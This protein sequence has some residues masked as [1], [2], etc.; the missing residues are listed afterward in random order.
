MRVYPLAAAAAAA[1][2]GVAGCSGGD[3]P[4]PASDTDPAAMLET[5][6]GLL[7]Q[8]SGLRFTME[9]ENLP[10]AGMVIIGADGLAAPPASFEGDI[11]IATSGL[12]ATIEVVS[13]N[14]Q[15]WAKLP[16]TEDFAQMDAASLGF[17]DPGLLLDPDHGVGQLLRSAEDPAHADQVRVG[18]EV[19]DQVTATLPGELVGRLLTITDPAAQVQA[20]FALDTGTG[21]LRQAILTGPFVPNGADQTYTVRLDDYDQAVD[22]SA[23]E[24]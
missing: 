19:F 18:S 10:D 24:D 5:A 16:L 3:E 4:E 11:R 17:S 22:I 21:H 2:L 6:A 20:V 14:G 9:G 13:V 7:G 12:A 15:L 1:V 8:T 23:P